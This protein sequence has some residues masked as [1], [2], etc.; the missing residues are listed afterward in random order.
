MGKATM[1][2]ADKKPCHLKMQKRQGV[3]KFARSRE[4][5]AV[6]AWRSGC[7][8]CSRSVIPMFQ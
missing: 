2:A 8:V 6:L 3:V 5:L 7:C 4:G 1:I